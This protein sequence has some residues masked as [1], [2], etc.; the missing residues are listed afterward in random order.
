[1]AGTRRPCPGA[2]GA[3]LRY[4]GLYRLV[5]HPPVAIEPGDSDTV[6][7]QRVATVLEVTIRDHPE[8]WYPFNKVYED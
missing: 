5:V 4:K 8:W 3:L 7:M 6:V 2:A 1:M